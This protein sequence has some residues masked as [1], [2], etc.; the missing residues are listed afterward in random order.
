MDFGTANVCLLEL[1]LV[2][3]WILKNEAQ[4]V[5]IFDARKWMILGAD[6]QLKM[7]GACLD[8]PKKKQGNYIVRSNSCLVF[9][10]KEICNVSS[11][12]VDLKRSFGSPMVL[13]N[14]QNGGHSIQATTDR[15]AQLPCSWTILRL[16]EYLHRA[17]IRSHSRGELVLPSLMGAD[18]GRLLAGAGSC[19][20]VAMWLAHK[21]ARESLLCG[22]LFS[23]V[24][25]RLDL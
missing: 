23:V 24:W 8:L 16:G 17:Y 5:D 25:F 9:V 3:M 20:S 13:S 4:A 21:A 2:L 7:L 22:V 11:D 12:H 19:C 1:E 15:M 18:G 6:K 14:R 10:L